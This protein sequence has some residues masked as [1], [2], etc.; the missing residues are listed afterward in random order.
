[1]KICKLF[2]AVV[3]VILSLIACKKPIDYTEVQTEDISKDDFDP[4]EM[5]IEDDEDAQLFYEVT[6]EYPDG[7]YCAEIEY[8]NPNTGTRSTYNL[9]V[10]VE[11]GDMVKIHWSNG[12]WLD[13]THFTPKDITDGD[14][15]F[16]SD[17][18]YKYTVTLQEFGGCGYTDEYKI[19]RDVNNDVEEEEIEKEEE[20]CPECGFSKFSTEELCSSCEIAI[21]CPKCGGRK[22]KYEN[23]CYSCRIIEDQEEN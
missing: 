7:T 16:T 8:Y 4:Y 20:T 5:D 6:G 2:L 3:L 11:N 15:S 13:E 12:G 10:D 1:M 19:R 18:G 22:E 17:R 14:C 23:L 21:T 9:D